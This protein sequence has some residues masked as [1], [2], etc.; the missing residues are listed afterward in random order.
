MLIVSLSLY[1]IAFFLSLLSYWN[2]VSKRIVFIPLLL[3]VLFYFLHLLFLSVQFGG[4]PYADIYSF[5]SL[6]GNTIIAILLGLSFKNPQLLRLFALFSFAGFLFSLLVLPSEASPYK[7]PLYTL[8]IVSALF[9]YTFAFFAG[10]SAVIRLLIEKSLKH[11]DFPNFSIPVDIL[12]SLEKT[13]FILSFIFFTLT[14]IFGSLWTRTHFGQ[15]WINDPKL[16][17]TFFLWLY[18]ALV[19][20]LNLMKRTK[21]KTFSFLIII[22]SLLSLLNL[23]LIRHEI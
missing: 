18:Y 21:P 13:T 19:S 15:H 12:M 5:V 7:N 8:H 1:V 9:S 6:L 16:I 2:K 3:A 11:K 14:L 17:F 4:F 23:L 10:L 22:G 20:H